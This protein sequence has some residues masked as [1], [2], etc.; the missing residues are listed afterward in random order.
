M[1]LGDSGREAW[2]RSV[3][4]G[5]VRGLAMLEEG[6]ARQ[7]RKHPRELSLAGVQVN[8]GQKGFT[9]ASTTMRITAI[10]GISPSIRSV[11]TGIGPSPLASFFE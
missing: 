9:T 4:V 1:H 3:G 2:E 11:R 6:C 5:D 8:G 7:D 10:A